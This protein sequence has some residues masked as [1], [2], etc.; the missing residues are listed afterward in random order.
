MVARRI[1]ARLLDIRWGAATRAFRLCLIGGPTPRAQAFRR[2]QS[3]AAACAALPL[4]SLLFRILSNNPSRVL[5][6]LSNTPSRLLSKFVE[7][8]SL[9]FHINHVIMK[10]TGN[11]S[12]RR[13]TPV[14]T[15]RFSF[16]PSS[17]TLLMEFRWSN[18]SEG[19]D[20]LRALSVIFLWQTL[21]Y[22]L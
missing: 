11:Y 17:F 14:P 19:F 18:S 8:F 5:P 7:R 20:S 22:L 15:L 3:R 10:S 6:N 12:F 1:A 13:S 4:S 21:F 16:L 2:S 9:F